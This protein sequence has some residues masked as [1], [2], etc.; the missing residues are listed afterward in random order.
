MGSGIVPFVKMSE[1]F[2]GKISVRRNNMAITL[3]HQVIPPIINP[4]PFSMFPLSFMSWL[5]WNLQ[6]KA[7]QRAEEKKMNTQKTINLINGSVSGQIMAKETI[8]TVIVSDTSLQRDK[9]VSSRGNAA[10]G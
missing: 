4:P 1:N 9:K 10:L 6:L 3:A 2:Q 5:T 8:K 7:Y